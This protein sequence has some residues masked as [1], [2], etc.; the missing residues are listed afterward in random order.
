MNGVDLLGL[1]TRG[2]GVGGNVSG[3]GG[4]I[5]GSAMVSEDDDGQRVLELSVEHGA[6][7]EWGGSLS[8]TYQSTDA[9]SVGQL[10]GRSSKVGGYINIPGTPV[11]IG[12]ERVDGGTYVG[13][14]FNGV[15]GRTSG[16]PVGASLKQENTVTF[17]IVKR[18]DSEDFDLW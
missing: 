10:E 7:P 9:N 18:D 4:I 1:R 14:N 16:P 17:P 8:G 5:G 2:I 6:S 12:A 13:T 15:F 3:F 11:G